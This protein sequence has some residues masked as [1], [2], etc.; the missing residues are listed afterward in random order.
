[1]ALKEENK[2]L[3]ERANDLERALHY[4]Q[5]HPGV[6]HLAGTGMPY[7]GLSVPPMPPASAMFAE[8]PMADLA[9]FRAP[10]G[11]ESMA[12]ASA[13]SSAA[14]ASAASA[15]AAASAAFLLPDQSPFPPF[16]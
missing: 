13:A 5:M 3:A 7:F 12:A 1:M 14:A 6:S 11:A 9:G 10:T 2:R 8:P 16:L 4:I 15:A